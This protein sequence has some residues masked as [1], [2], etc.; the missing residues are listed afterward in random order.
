MNEFQTN[1]SQSQHPA[2]SH[3]WSGCL[4]LQ[5][6]LSPRRG[7]S[8]AA[9]SRFTSSP[10]FS[11]ASAL[12]NSHPHC[13]GQPKP[14]VG[15]GTCQ[16]PGNKPPCWLLPLLHYFFPLHGLAG[17]VGQLVSLTGS[18][19]RSGDLRGC[20]SPCSEVV[21]SGQRGWQEFLGGWQWGKLCPV[22]SP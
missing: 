17:S 20:G 6:S 4:L 3:T 12:S 2:V 8:S 19:W 22:C 9:P 10:S 5:P 15:R 16:P 13:C 14:R 18:T 21:W 11:W 1:S 7:I